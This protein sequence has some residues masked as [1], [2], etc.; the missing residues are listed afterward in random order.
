MWVPEFDASVDAARDD[1]VPLARVIERNE[2]LARVEDH[3]PVAR[4]PLHVPR[5]ETKK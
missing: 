5:F 3:V 2:A 1:E 4:Q